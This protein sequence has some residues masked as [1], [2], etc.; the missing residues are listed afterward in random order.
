MKEKALNFNIYFSIMRFCINNYYYKQI[1]K[2]IP[3][4]ILGL[5]S[6][7]RSPDFTL[8]D[9][10]HRGPERAVEVP[11]EVGAVRKRTLHPV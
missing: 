2:K 3:K 5:D 1:D 7:H 9:R 11:R 4:M 8:A 6:R 10:V